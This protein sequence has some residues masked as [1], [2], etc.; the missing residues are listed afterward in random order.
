VGRVPLTEQGAPDR[1][2][3][4]AAAQQGAG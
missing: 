2:A 3:I 4:R 1:A